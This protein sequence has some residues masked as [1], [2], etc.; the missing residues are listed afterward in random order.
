VWSELIWSP[1]IEV[2]GNFAQVWAPYAFYV[3]KTFHHCG[4][5]AFHLFKNAAGEW[6]IFQLSDTRQKEGCNV[7]KKVTIQL[8]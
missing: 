1:K 3:D 2:D 6:K 4:V 8:K 5:D 7:P